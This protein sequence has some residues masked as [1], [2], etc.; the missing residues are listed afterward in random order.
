MKMRSIL[1]LVVLLILAGAAVG[2]VSYMRQFAKDK[3][4]VLVI[5]SGDRALP[6]AQRFLTEVRARPENQKPPSAFRIIDLSE[7]MDRAGRTDFGDY[8]RVFMIHGADVEERPLPGR[9]QALLP[10]R[11]RRLRGEEGYAGG[12]ILKPVQEGLTLSLALYAPDDERFDLLYRETLT[13]N[14]ANWREMRFSASFTTNRLH[15]FTN[16]EGGA[17]RGWGERNRHGVWDLVTWHPLQE[18]TEDRVAELARIGSVAVLVD[19][20]RP[21]PSTA[22][23]GFRQFLLPP[24]DAQA[25]LA[26][27]RTNVFGHDIVLLSAPSRRLLQLHA[28]DFGEP[29]QLPEDAKVTTTLDLRHLSLGGLHLASKDLGLRAAHSLEER[30]AKRIMDEAGVPLAA[31][32]EQAA[33]PFRWQV[34]LMDLE[35]LPA[36]FAYQENRLTKHPGEYP[37]GRPTRPSKPR[38]MSETEYR[39]RLHQHES[40]LSAWQQRKR[41]WEHERDHV[42]PVTFQ[43][44]VARTVAIRGRVGLE[45]LDRRSNQVLW[46]QEVPIE[47][48]HIDA[49]YYRD[50]QVVMGFTGE[51]SRVPEPRYEGDYPPALLENLV[52]K[53]F[54]TLLDRLMRTAWLPG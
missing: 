45:L 15:V 24:P 43:R 19:R 31:R 30:L 48:S 35:V 49:A 20:S 27:R 4:P 37:I 5:V 2:E 50:T 39:V 12:A 46:Q 38:G 22:A 32:G 53:G 29:S 54:G 52:E 51:P 47:M 23:E 13:R 10:S 3:A 36:L 6:F 41:S 7:A 16:S 44:T 11:P 8:S 40:D 26:V 42:M 25:V 21:S 33:N 34:H 1:S 14:F 9:L 17:L 18:A 28:R